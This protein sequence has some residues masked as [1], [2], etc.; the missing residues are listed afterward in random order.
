[1]KVR[2]LVVDP[3]KL[4]EFRE[5]ELTEE[6]VIKFSKDD[7]MSMLDKSRTYYDAYQVA[8]YVLCE[9]HDCFVEMVTDKHLHNIRMFVDEEGRCKGLPANR[10]IIHQNGSMT[11][12]AGRLVI[13]PCYLDRL[14]G[15]VIVD[16]DVDSDGIRHDFDMFL[17]R[18]NNDGSGPI[19]G[20]DQ[21]ESDNISNSQR[22][23]TFEDF[24][25]VM[26]FLDSMEKGDGFGRN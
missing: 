24:E 25:D 12:I 14:T 10:R 5:V 1:M 18:N 11:L 22:V 3:N 17:E 21:E 8:R 20:V 9:Y 19:V 15:W 16:T 4:P 2:V 23:Y 7:D 13:V 26:R 6:F